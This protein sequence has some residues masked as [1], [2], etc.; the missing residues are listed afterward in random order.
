MY[1]L[2]D[3]LTRFFY[4]L[5]L[6]K[7]AFFGRIWIIRI[8][9]PACDLTV[10]LFRRTF[11][12]LCIVRRSS[13]KSTWL[14]VFFLTGKTKPIEVRGKVLAVLFEGFIYSPVYC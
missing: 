1:E 12:I 4:H 2:S 11:L 8:P 7:N 5:K 9:S 14:G 13:Y 3:K 10:L 6:V